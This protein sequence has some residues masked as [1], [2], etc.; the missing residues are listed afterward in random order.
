MDKKP[1][2]Q[3]NWNI[4]QTYFKVYTSKL[5]EER[6]KIHRKILKCDFFVLV[7][8]Q[9]AFPCCLIWCV[10][11]MGKN[12]F[13]YVIVVVVEG[14]LWNYNVNAEAS[15]EYTWNLN[16]CW[17]NTRIG[18]KCHHKKVLL[19]QTMQKQIYVTLMRFVVFAIYF[20]LFLTISWNIF[21]IFFLQRCLCF[22]RRHSWLSVRIKPN[23][24]ISR[25]RVVEITFY[26]TALDIFQFQ[27]I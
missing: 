20:F 19:M 5:S 6:E 17:W 16:E 23:K 22:I 24:L 15:T 11:R 1:N 14:K 12:M 21:S 9:E 25:E 10:A 2:K 27:T 8:R 13:C 3:T 18:E 4:Q 7:E 26:A